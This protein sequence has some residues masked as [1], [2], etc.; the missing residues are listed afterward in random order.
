MGEI[1][2]P[3]YTVRMSLEHRD[4]TKGDTENWTRVPL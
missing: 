2:T 3:T 4:V 1:K